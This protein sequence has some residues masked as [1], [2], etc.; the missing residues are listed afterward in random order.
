MLSR[1]LK[2]LLFVA[3][4]HIALGH[5]GYVHGV[6]K[7]KS[8]GE[9]VAGA[10]IYVREIS[11][12]TSTDLF[13]RFHLQLKPG[14]YSIEVSFVGF[15]TQSFL[16][17]IVEH[18]TFTLSVLLE[19]GA[20]QLSDL[21]ILSSPVSNQMSH[22]SQVDVALRPVNSSQD[23][24]RM[25]PGLFIAQHAGGGKAEQIFLRG[26]DTD[27]G[28]DISIMVDGMPVN[29]V[30]HAHGQGYSDL[31]FLIPETINTVDFEKGTYSV[32]HGNFTTAGYVNFNTDNTI[33]KNSIKIES[34]AYGLFRNVN[35]L[36]IFDRQ[37]DTKREQLNIASEFFR[38]DGYFESPQGF[39]RIN[40]IA[41]YFRRVK[42][43]SMFS[44]SASGFSSK[45]NASGQIPE[46]A[47]KDGSI[48]RFGAIDDTEGGNT[49]R[50]NLNLSLNTRFDSDVLQQQFFASLYEFDLISNFTFFLNDPVNGDRIRQSESRKLIGYQ[51]N[52]AAEKSFHKFDL[53]QNFGGGFRYDDVDD[54][55]LSHVL[56]DKVTLDEITSGDVHET[57]LFLFTD[58]T[59]SFGQKFSINAGFRLDRFIFE[60]DDALTANAANSGKSIFSP[61]VN[62]QYNPTALTTLFI[63]A[64]YGFHSN[65][66]RAILSEQTRELLPRAFG[67]DAGSEWKPFADL[68]LHA[69]LWVLDLEEE[70]LFVGDE[71]IVEPSGATRRKGVDLSFRYQLSDAV[72][73]DNDLTY[74][75]ARSVSSTDNSN[76]IPLAPL[77]TST[78]GI[79]YQR[80]NF[81]TSLRYRYLA[82]RPANEDNSLQAEGYLLLDA[83]ASCTYGKFT[84]RLAAENLFNSEWDE[85]QFETTSRLKNETEPVTEI[86]FTPGTPLMIKGSVEIR[87]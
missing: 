76:Y 8:S 35:Q 25:V 65:D 84:F 20:V 66:S 45:W 63:K 73:I 27:H 40:V 11:T 77:F 87:F 64:G 70:L 80:N 44:L 31:H 71:G 74:T 15:T 9:P 34:G 83:T 3:L 33:E 5:N 78:G 26:F 57:N 67:I 1:C 18:E 29:M 51:I 37:T 2:T 13:G 79:Q 10:N 42:D 41:K 22:L 24:L 59:V 58:H 21:V 16:V 39:K 14:K 23:V 47:V 6:V 68:F 38:S 19:S 4:S 50:Y 43:R 85:A 62:L 28:T 69:S 55:E 61:K 17:E 52:Y 56:N 53:S 54:I 72:F 81:T 36:K 32:D 82:D 60:Y 49:S 30:S 46:R 48:T 7:E 86:H 75:L 12:G